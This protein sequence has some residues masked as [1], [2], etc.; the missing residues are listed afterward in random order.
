MTTSKAAG[1]VAKLR[2]IFSVRDPAYGARG[3]G[4]TDDTAA[5]QAAV[6]A[7]NAANADVYFPAGTYKLTGAITIYSNMRLFGV[8]GHL[9]SL[10]R[11]FTSNTAIFTYANAEGLEIDHL[12]F[13][14]NAVT[15]VTAI[16]QTDLTAYTASSHFHHNHFYADLTHCIH[17]N[18]ILCDVGPRNTFGYYGTVQTSHSHIYSQGDSSNSSNINYVYDNRFFASAGAGVGVTFDHGFLLVV[19]GNDFESSSVCPLNILGMYVSA[20]RRNW[21]ENNNFTSYLT[22]ANSTPSTNPNLSSLVES[23]YFSAHANMTHLIQYSGAGAVAFQFNTG[24]GFAGKT[25]TNTA[26]AFL[27]RSKGNALS[28]STSVDNFDTF[29]TVNTDAVKFPATQVSSSDAN[30]LDDY[31]EGSFTGTLTGATGGTTTNTIKYTKVGREVNLTCHADYS[32]T[33]NAVTK[34][35]TGMPA[36]A[37][38]SDT[39]RGT[40]VG[41]DNAGSY[42]V[43]L[44]VIAATGVITLYNTPGFTDWTASGAC[45]VLGFQITYTA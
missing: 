32:S 7:A 19:E 6:T 5:I 26:D 36:E 28:G 2:P 27:G 17:A 12:A 14:T 9:G 25:I 8:G 11:Q 16:K 20:V 13:F 29:T 33:S 1:N 41:K 38:P 4:S 42:F 21:F 40:F 31:Q 37:R 24:T 34:T 43:G 15:G 30:T 3:D 10:L 22:Y 45:E 35:I 44:M 23:N 18:L 39:V